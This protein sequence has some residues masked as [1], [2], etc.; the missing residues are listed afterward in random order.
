MAS[1]FNFFRRNQRSMMVVLVILAMLVFT[2]DSVFMSQ[3]PHF[4]ILGAVLGGLFL[5]FAGIGQGKWLQ[6]AAGGALLGGACGWLMPG[7]IMPAAERST[8]VSSSLG[9]FDSPRIAEMARNRSV[10][11]QFMFQA[12]EE[13]YGQGMGQFARSA[14]FGFGHQD[15]RE[16][17]IFTELMRAEADSL[18]IVVTNDMVSQ[19]INEA[20]DNKLTAKAF[21]KIR[22]MLN[23]EGQKLREEQLFDILRNEVKPRLA[24]R[25]LQPQLSAMP[26]GPEMYYDTFRR[27]NVTQKLNTALIDVDAFL[28]KVEEPSD[29]DVSQ[30]FASA[31]TKFRIR[32]HPDHPDFDSRSKRSWDTLNSAEKKLLPRLLP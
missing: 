7:F 17:L 18:G 29:S 27:L 20:T 8:A 22:G 6:Y 1:P 13:A 28:S 24:Y 30:L 26:P 2:L 5:A 31:M 14:S 19:Y 12:F 25:M 4:V 16:D 9:I 10:A 15:D 21:A 11:N 3:E 23:I 32:M